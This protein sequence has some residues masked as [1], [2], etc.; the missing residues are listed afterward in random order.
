LLAAPPRLTGT[1]P[2]AADP[3]AWEYLPE[4]PAGYGGSFVGTSGGALVVAGGAYFPVSLFDGGT[5]EWVDDI[6]I[7]S[8]GAK[9]WKQGFKLNRPTAYGA[10]IQTR[11]GILLI[12]G[13]DA[14]THFSQCWLLAYRDGRIKQTKMPDLPS[15]CAF[16][17]A[18]RV[19]T[20]VYVAGGLAKPGDKSAM[21]NFW[22]YDLSTRNGKWVELPS[23]PG[24]PRTQAV[25][26]AHGGAFYLFSGTDFD[27]DDPDED[28]RVFLTDAYRYTPKQG[29]KKLA[30][31][32]YAVAAAPGPAPAI[33]GRILILGGADASN[34]GST[35]RLKEKHPGFTHDVLA[36]D[37]GCDRW[38]K[39]GTMPE[40]V[41]T[42]ETT[43]WQGR[44]VIATGED[45]PGHRSKKVVWAAPAAERAATAPESKPEHVDVFVSGR[46]GY[47]T[48]RI[49][50][51]VRTN[52]GTLLAFCEGRKTGRGDHGDL[53]LV[54]RR[55]KDDG[56]TWEPMTLVYEEG[57]EKKITIGN[58]APVVE[59]QTGTIWLPFCRNNSDV[60]ITHSKDDGLTWSE[61]RDIT[62]AV[63][64]PDWNWYA[65]GPVNG[66]QLQYGPHKGRLVIPC[67]HRV[68]GK[69]DN[70]WQHAGRSH[71]IY[72][73]DRGVTWKL[74]EPTDWAMNECTVVER[75]DG[76]LMLNMRS[77]RGKNRRA[78]ALSSDGGV[79]WSECRDDATLIE[80][81]CQGSL[82][83]L[84]ATPGSDKNRL[85]FSNPAS[86]R[87]NK[88]TIRMSYDE[89]KSWPVARELIGGSAA[90]SNLIV[91]PGGRIGCLYERDNYSRICFARFDLDWLTRGKDQPKKPEPIPRRA[92]PPNPSQSTN[93]S[94]S[95]SPSA[96]GK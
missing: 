16:M 13:G 93:S 82:L 66:I 29:W 51:I 39:A 55:S 21:K 20:L 52:E 27:R 43:P 36:Y 42:T 26:A 12:G 70:S 57:G 56:K 40:S 10:S 8:P 79:T 6:S 87:R 24:R 85:L 73:D 63:K 38:A 44:I 59:R 96:S 61:P 76:V 54:L 48:Y 15:P 46:G 30:D 25:A 37:P 28:N 53:D 41:V 94:K 80:P 89:G 22:C 33:G 32:P 4:L 18:A 58:P 95:P 69:S 72:S 88:L 50:S 31:L 78:V 84:T 17:A 47:H 81:V 1:K 5:K 92:S 74:G 11:D 68:K 67:D 35:F 3:L 34:K 60:L 71:V 75:T 83:R 23:W 65:T 9:Q 77:Y 2:P 14:K 45:R 62:A 90:Y 19:E 64:K 7:L 86:K 91:L 49:P